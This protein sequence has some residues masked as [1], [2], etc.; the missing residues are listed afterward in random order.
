MTLPVTLALLRSPWG[1][2]PRGVVFA[3][4]AFDSWLQ[5][6]DTAGDGDAYGREAG[7]SEAGAATALVWPRAR[8]SSQKWQAAKWF[9][10]TSSS[11]G[12]FWRHRSWANGQ[13]G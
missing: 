9:G 7:D 2:A 10:S 11:G 6:G 4:L 1:G 13:R 12:S 8:I 5:F 3:E